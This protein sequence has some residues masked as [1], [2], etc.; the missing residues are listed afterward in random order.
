[1]DDMDLQ[2]QTQQLAQ[3]LQEAFPDMNWDAN[4]EFGGDQ[5]L[6]MPEATD[7]MQQLGTSILCNRCCKTHRTPALLL[8]WTHS[9]R[10][11][12]GRESA[13]ALQRLS[14]WRVYSK[15]RTRTNRRS[16]ELT[17]RALRA[18]GRLLVISSTS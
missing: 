11:T 15:K 3:H 7:V 4:Y 10:R 12:L 16:T 2:W 1:M 14:E 5:Q 6:N 17:P 18:I 8:K 13:E 9:G